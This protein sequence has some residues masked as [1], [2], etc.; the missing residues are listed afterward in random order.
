MA[1]LPLGVRAVATKHMVNEQSFCG[2][3]TTTALWRCSCL[4]I[5]L[6]FAVFWTQTAFSP[7][8]TC[9]GLY[10]NPLSANVIFSKV[11][12]VQ[13]YVACCWFVL[14]TSTAPKSTRRYR[15]DVQLFRAGSFKNYPVW[16]DWSAIVNSTGNCSRRI[17]VCVCVWGGGGGVLHNLTM[18]NVDDKLL[19]LLLLLLS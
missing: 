3:L 2:N 1:T 17:C 4:A 9:F 15:D 8:P 16:I 14:T 5:V 10:L 11:P 19:L 12:N 7:S 13:R 6:H 18:N